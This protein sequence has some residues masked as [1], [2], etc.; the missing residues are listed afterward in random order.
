MIQATQ[1]PTYYNRE[2]MY[3]RP[4]KRF[5]HRTTTTRTGTTRAPAELVRSWEAFDRLFEDA[6]APSNHTAGSDAGTQTGYKAGS[7]YTGDNRSQTDFEP[8]TPV[9]QQ[10]K[11]RFPPQQQQRQ[12][13]P[14]QQRYQQQQSEFDYYPEQTPIDTEFGQLFDDGASEMT[15]APL[16]GSYPKSYPG[17]TPSVDQASLYAGEEPEPYSSITANEDFQRLWDEAAA[18]KRKRM[19]RTVTRRRI[20]QHGSMMSPNDSVSTLQPEPE[21]K[22]LRRKK[23]RFHLYRNADPDMMT[24]TFDLPDVRKE[25]VH[26]AFQTSQLTITWESVLTTE[27]RESDRTVIRERKERKYA[28]TLPLPPGT[29]FTDIKAYLENGLL[30]VMYPKFPSAAPTQP[31]G[32]LP[33]TRK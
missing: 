20:L 15:E 7:Y 28:R 19:T 10:Y 21:Q 8:A 17:M 2:P 1:S 14:Q 11:Q 22:Q 18:N 31:R 5:E 26:V 3:E 29:Q 13:Q 6:F 30:T 27:R 16:P 23:S 12:P 32:P 33:I 25:D 4:P 9:Q 24:A